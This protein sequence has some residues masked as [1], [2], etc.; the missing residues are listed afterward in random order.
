M[1]DDL[2]LP[3][4]GREVLLAVADAGFARDVQRMLEADFARAREE[5]LAKYRTG[6]RW[7][8]AKA[9]LARLLAPIQ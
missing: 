8:R 2:G 4:V 5:D 1:M 9:R 3:F 6:S 7:F